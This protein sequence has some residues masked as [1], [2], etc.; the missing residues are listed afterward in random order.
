MLGSGPTVSRRPA[1]VKTSRRGLDKDS[2]RARWQ[3]GMPKIRPASSR[4]PFEFSSAI[5]ILQRCGWSFVPRKRVLHNSRSSGGMTSELLYLGI[6][7]SIF[8]GQHPDQ[9]THQ[10]ATLQITFALDQ[11]FEIRTPGVPWMSTPGAG[12]AP[13]V[14]HQFRRFQ[15]TGVSL[16][17]VPEARYTKHL[18]EGFLGGEDIRVLDVQTL[19]PYERFLRNTLLEPAGCSEVFLMAERLVEDLTGTIGYKGVADERLLVALDWIESEL[20]RQ[21]SMKKLAHHVCLSEDRFLHL[22]TEQLGLPLRPYV[23]NQRIMRATVEVLEGR[24]ITQAAVSAGFSDTAHF[25]RT[26][27]RLTGVHPSIIKKHRGTVKVSTCSSSRCI[28]PTVLNPKGD[29]CMSCV[30]NRARTQPAG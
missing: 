15:G 18:I 28:R 24:S 19:G 3:R 11:R 20:P 17:F 25:S 8:V 22:F 10:H 7:R 1:L 9:A 2:G 5:C 16:H 29:R 6:G 14:P 4:L 27:L 23:L 21:I 30:L 26:F 13:N 12:I